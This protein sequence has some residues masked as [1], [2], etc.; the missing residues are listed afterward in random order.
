MKIDFQPDLYTVYGRG[1]LHIAILLENMRREGFE[2]QVSQPHVIMKKIDGC[3]LEP[4]EE[5]TVQVPDMHAGTVIDKIGIRKGLLISMESLGNHKRMLFEIPTRALLGYRTELVVDTKG[6][7]VMYSR[8]LGFRPHVDEVQRRQV[9]SMISK[10][11]RA[12]PPLIPCDHLQQR[13][14]LY[15]GPGTEVYEG[16]II[17][18][19]S[20]GDD[21]TVNPVKGK[22]LTNTRASGADDAIQLVPASEICIERGLEIMGEDDYL[23]ITPT[24]VRLRKRFLAAADR[25]R[26]Y[27]KKQKAA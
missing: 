11:S 22:H 16:M 17:G 21:M 10:V 26:A 24:N 19:S 7:G 18:N 8:V 13:G 14:T 5:L 23:E 9:G 25:R 6:E 1:E 3:T 27:R 2:V 4:F 12:G 20:K 15:I